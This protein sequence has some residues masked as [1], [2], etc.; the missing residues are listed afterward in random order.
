LDH[1]TTNETLCFVVV[2]LTNNQISDYQ[3]SAW[4]TNQMQVPNNQ[5]LFFVYFNQ[6]QSKT[7]Q[8]AVTNPST[9]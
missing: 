5:M 2:Q 3:T 6:N 4:L 8:L 1:F 9:K 7:I